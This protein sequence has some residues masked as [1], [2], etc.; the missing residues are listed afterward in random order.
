MADK[1]YKITFELSD[2]SE[3]SVEFTSPQGDPGKSAYE[4]ARD[5]G[6]SGTEEEFAEKL[7]NDSGNIEMTDRTTGKKYSLYVDNGKL[8]ME[9]VS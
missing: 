6:Y 8:L 9:E 7:A 1:K 4:Y 5:G 3:K 2:G